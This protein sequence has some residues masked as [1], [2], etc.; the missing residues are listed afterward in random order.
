[1][2]KKI[3]FFIFTCCTWYVTVSA[4]SDVWWLIIHLTTAPKYYWLGKPTKVSPC[5]RLSQPRQYNNR[6]NAKMYTRRR[7]RTKNSPDQIFH[8]VLDVARLHHYKMSSDWPC[9]WQPRQSIIGAE[10]QRESQ[11]G[12]DYDNR[13]NKMQKK[14]K[15]AES[16]SLN[17]L[18][19][20]YNRAKT[21]R[22]FFGAVLIA[23][24]CRAS[25]HLSAHIFTVSRT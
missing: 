11:I 5:V 3:T 1:L 4:L 6:K 8:T 17:T 9:I 15:S 18:F 13:A 24:L 10:N 23:D 16:S 2:E 25:S 14:S 22:V 21:L 7:L 19:S 12:C 20:P